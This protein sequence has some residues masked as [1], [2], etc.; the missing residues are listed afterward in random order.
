MIVLAA[1]LIALFGKRP[2]AF[3]LGR[4]GIAASLAFRIW[5]WHCFLLC[6]LV[7]PSL[8]VAILDPGISNESK[9]VRRLKPVSLRTF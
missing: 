4:A 9:K 6:T 5:I 1:P 2:F 7:A 8:M 3:L